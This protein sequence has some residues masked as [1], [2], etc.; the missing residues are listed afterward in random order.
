MKGEEYTVCQ[1]HPG[2]LIPLSPSG[3]VM[4]RTL[5]IQRGCHPESSWNWTNLFQ[6]MSANEVVMLETWKHYLGSCG[7]GK[8]HSQSFVT[9]SGVNNWHHWE[10]P[11]HLLAMQNLRPLPGPTQSESALNKTCRWWLAHSSSE[12][13]CSNIIP[14]SHQ[15]GRWVCGLSQVVKSAPC[16]H[17]TRRVPLILKFLILLWSHRCLTWLCECFRH[18]F[19]YFYLT[20]I[21]L[22][23]WFITKSKIIF[24]KDLT[25]LDSL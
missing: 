17:I 11:G 14:S 5:H 25:D 1:R 12:R 6:T 21:I 3:K 23:I 20:Y 9:R 8:L 4:M 16:R 18:C 19:D 15:Q 22:L 2:N 13:F 7:S 24:L 10:N